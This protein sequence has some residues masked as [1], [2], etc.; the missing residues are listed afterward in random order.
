M[1]GESGRL[2]PAVPVRTG[3]VPRPPVQV[4][5]LRRPYLDDVNFPWC[6][7]GQHSVIHPVVR[8]SQVWVALL[9]RQITPRLLPR[10]ASPTSNR[11]RSLL[12]RATHDMDDSGVDVRRRHSRA[13]S[14]PSFRPCALRLWQHRCPAGSAQVHW[15][16]A[17]RRAPDPVQVPGASAA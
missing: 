14:S 12:L 15:A 11:W 4:Y 17:I 5:I 2:V 9:K 10:L 6:Q 16:G 13:S 7:L 1:P 8:S 3:Q